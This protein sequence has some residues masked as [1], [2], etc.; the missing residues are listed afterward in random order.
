MRHGDSVTRP[1]YYFYC[2]SNVNNV[3]RIWIVYLW[4]QSKYN[5][6]QS[7]TISDCCHTTHTCL[8]FSSSHLSILQFLCRGRYIHFS[9]WLGWKLDPDYVSN[10]FLEKFICWDQWRSE[11][12]AEGGKCPRRHLPWGRHFRFKKTTNY[13]KLTIHK[14]T[15]T[16]ASDQRMEH[17]K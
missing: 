6:C 7:Q 10:T 9:I 12:G 1:D 17:S 14:V 11:G 16:L 15:I 2:Y 3:L 4:V 5:S 13:F 8:V